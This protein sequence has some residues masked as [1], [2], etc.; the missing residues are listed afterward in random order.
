MGIRTAWSTNRLRALAFVCVV[1]AALAL[2]GAPAALAWTPGQSFAL[3]Y[4]RLAMWWPNTWSQS[5]AQLARYDT[6]VMGEGD[7]HA[8]SAIRA[9]N[10][11]EILMTAT[12]AC[13]LNIDADKPPS[14]P[15]N[16][17]IAQVPAS[18]ILTQ[19]G[20][21]LTAPVDAAA[22]KLPVS[23]TTAMSPS[24]ATIELFVPGDLVV[25]G[26]EIA[27]V[28][29]VDSAGHTL[30]VRRGIAKVAAAHAAA[31]RVAATISFWPDS[32][33]MDLSGACPRATADSAVGPETWAEYNARQGAALALDDAWDGIM[34][35]RSDGDESWLIGNST[36]RSMD[37]DRSNRVPASYSAFD[38]SWDTGLLG[39]E[40]HLRQSIGDGRLIETNWGYPNFSLLNGNNMEGFPNVDKIGYA[41]QEEVVGPSPGNGSYFEW[42]ANARQPNL[43]TIETYQDDSLT[44]PTGDGSYANPMAQPGFVPNYQKMRYGL[45]TALM[46]DGF[47]SYEI[48]TDGHGS[49]GLMWFDEY[50]GAGLGRGYLGQPA[51]PGHRVW[52]PLPTADLLGG[53]GHFDTIAQFGAWTSSSSE[54]GAGTAVRDTSTVHAGAGSLRVN[55]SR[56]GSNAWNV[57]SSHP[58]A[59]QGN[60]EY[61]IS[62]WA[63]SDTTRT[64]SPW[65]QQAHS[66]WNCLDYFGPAQVTPRWQRFVLTAACSATDSNARLD[67]GFGTSA[68]TVWVDDVTVQQ[69][70][71]EVWIR[72]FANGE[73][74]VNATGSTVSV[75]LGGVYRKLRGTQVA[76][77][78]DGTLVSSVTL[79]P[80]DG[81]VVVNASVAET[82][83][84]PGSVPGTTDPL[85]GGDGTA[86]PPASTPATT[87][88]AASAARIAEPL[89]SARIYSSK[90]TANARKAAAVFAKK[91]KHGSRAA[92]RRAAAATAAWKRSATRA[93]TL[94]RAITTAQIRLTGA[95]CDLSPALTVAASA[96]AKASR[97]AAS[98]YKSGRT[99]SGRAAISAVSAA[100]RSLNVAL[101]A[102]R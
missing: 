32:V 97:Y 5:A 13:E 65:I 92:R 95:G 3:P 72:R 45:T 43:T 61:T 53:D 28:R 59:V 49:L 81:I 82:A 62:F 98:A 78:N 10:P 79:P 54:G 55:V 75:P 56:A 99:S 80:Y 22:T 74:V 100:R 19:V 34:V 64:V 23:A 67:L 39:Y 46:G 88:P 77:V 40:L 86:T 25:L 17:Q 51:E 44:S 18:W 47:F 89:A 41:W 85:G 2:A 33:L 26:D 9:L 7:R 71:P 29:S 93:D 57:D 21:Q 102:T 96:G 38:A 69:G 11:N 91:A 20:A 58:V 42:L 4:P 35:D 30:T 101:A 76:S 37:P 24:G 84:P 90:A 50:D 6:L 66:P 83:G 31:T 68:T 63:R 14:D 12:N 27:Q 60:R 15:D 52:D 94:T 8:I 48:N 70:N 16:A 36:A 73:A 87:G 1:A